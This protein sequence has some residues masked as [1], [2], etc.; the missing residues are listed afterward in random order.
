M[1]LDRDCGP[2]VGRSSGAFVALVCAV[3]CTQTPEQIEMANMKPSTVIPKVSPKKLIASFKN[4]C[5]DRIDQ[6]SSIPAHLRTIDYIEAEPW[7]FDGIR[8]FVVDDSKPMIR[9]K[10]GAIPQC[11]A[12]AEARSGQTAS[13]DR[14]IQKQ[15]PDAIP[16]SA[17]E[18]GTPVEKVW[19]ISET[20]EALIYTHRY[21]QPFPKSQFALGIISKER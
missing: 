21:N 4:Y 3:G 5:V 17:E 6:V 19:K 12:L 16:V 9:V 2:R 15:Y 8:T 18:L 13:V 7:S 11:V 1:G 14:F 20:P 10:T